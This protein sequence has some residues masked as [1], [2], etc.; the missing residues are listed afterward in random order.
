MINYSKEMRHNGLELICDGA[1][2]AYILDELKK[3]PT[4]ILHTTV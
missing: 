2:L 4:E 3:S 1:Q